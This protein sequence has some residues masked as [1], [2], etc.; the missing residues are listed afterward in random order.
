[1][2]PKTTKAPAANS[3]IARSGSLEPSSAPTPMAS[4][5]AATIPAVE[6]SQTPIGSLLVA[7]VMVASIVLSPSSAR[8]NAV[9]MATIAQRVERAARDS[10]LLT[11]VIAADRPGREGKEGEPGHDVDDVRRQSQRERRAQE[12]R[13]RVDDQGR[14]RDRDQ[15]HPGR[16]AGGEG[17]GHQLALVAQ[18]GEQHDAEAEPEGV[19]R[20]LRL[21]R[22]AGIDLDPA[23]GDGCW[24]KVS[25]A[26]R[27]AR[28]PGAEAPACRSAGE[29][30]L[31]FDVSVAP[32]GPW[33]QT[34]SFS[35]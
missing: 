29:G 35:T 32:G 13:H 3:L 14:D 5:S 18:L 8:K 20:C 16:V 30:L 28:R 6:P 10:S 17:E 9:P 7:S 4:A 24:S 1:M 12:D 26:P 2:A 27:G 25:S 33:R 23:P 34:P 19:H 11:E 15:H 21:G 31:P 22:R